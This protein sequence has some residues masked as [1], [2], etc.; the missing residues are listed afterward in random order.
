MCRGGGDSWQKLQQDSCSW[1][2]V[3][4]TKQGAKT[5]SSKEQI[6]YIIEKGLKVILELLWV[7]RRMVSARVS[8]REDRAGCQGTVDRRSEVS[9]QISW[10]LWCW[11][12]ATEPITFPSETGCEWK[13]VCSAVGVNDASVT[14]GGNFTC[15]LQIQGTSW[16][17][18]VLL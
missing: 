11:M 16:S 8:R 13:V 7:S 14:G 18:Q 5:S 9:S 2:A 6:I 1:K 15:M 17:P 10:P 3:R 4:T 12:M